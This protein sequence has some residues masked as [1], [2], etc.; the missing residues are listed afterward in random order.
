MKK[1][2]ST[3]AISISTPVST[4]VT[5]CP[6]VPIVP[7][8]CAD[9]LTY[10]LKTVLDY[11]IANNKNF[12]T[13]ATDFLEA[14][15]IIPKADVICCP[16]CLSAP[17]YSLTTV[18]TFVTLAQAM[19][20]NSSAPNV[21]DY[22]CINVDAFLETYGY[23]TNTM[24]SGGPLPNCCNNGFTDCLKQINS[25]VNY[26]TILNLGVAEVNTLNGE[27]GVCKLY[28]FLIANSDLITYSST[29]TNFIT[30]FL[31]TGF[32]T[33]CC[34]CNVFFGSK[35]NFVSYQSSGFCPDLN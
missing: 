32:V 33:Y 9:P 2:C 14:G 30:D 35:S 17:F 31:T 10:F 24:L 21:I 13:A 6:E 25:E 12:D 1:K 23:F 26:L 8:G 34:G 5:P 11:S 29:I 28:E 3:N 18:N 22:C 4:C 16:D 15:M 20:W 7:A 27:S 19:H